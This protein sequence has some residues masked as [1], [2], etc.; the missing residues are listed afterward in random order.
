MR[1]SKLFGYLLNCKHSFICHSNTSSCTMQ[2]MPF[3]NN[4]VKWFKRKGYSKFKRAHN[5][6][7]TRVFYG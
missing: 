1:H 3:F 7:S 4:N 5:I 6:N 2:I